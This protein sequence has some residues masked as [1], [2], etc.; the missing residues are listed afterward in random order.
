MIASWSGFVLLRVAFLFVCL[1]AMTGTA[2]AASHYVY[3]E[4]VPGTEADK[5]WVPH[6]AWTGGCSPTAASSAL[7]YWDNFDFTNGGWSGYSHLIDYYRI[8]MT[9]VCNETGSRR[10]NIPNLLFE[11]RTEMGTSCQDHDSDGTV[12]HGGTQSSVIRAGIENAANNDGYAFTSRRIESSLFGDG[13]DWCWGVITTEI[14]NNRPFAWSVSETVWGLFAGS[15]HTMCAIGY[16]DDKRV[17]VLDS[18]FGT[19]QEWRYN[20]WEYTPAGGAYGTQVDTV[21]PGGIDGS[22]LLALYSPVGGELIPAGSVFPIWWYQWGT[23]FTHADIRFSHDGGLSWSTVARVSSSGEGW[24]CYDWNVPN[25]ATPGARILVS[26][27]DGTTCRGAARSRTNFSISPVPVPPPAD[28]AWINTLTP[29]LQWST[30]EGSGNTVDYG[31][32]VRLRCDTDGDV[33]V[34]D[35]GL[36]WDTTPTSHDYQPGAYSGVDP[37]TSD[38]RYSEPLE[39][40]KSYHWHV[41]LFDDPD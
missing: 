20:Y 23:A 2:H 8:A 21:E 3:G 34:Y 38:Q 22:N 24:H 27:D 37:W 10:Y 12:D 32:Q 28:G 6:F 11:L 30:L 26:G 25:N 41:R 40:G 36:V 19:E 17:I 16:T 4:G 9:R 18:N 5:N 1:L 33:V 15:G 14:D 29:T 13:A 7:G 39:N 35:T 31:Y